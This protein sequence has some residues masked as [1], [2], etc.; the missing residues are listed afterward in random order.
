MTSGAATLLGL[1]VG[2]APLNPAAYGLAA[3]IASAT[4]L[5]NDAANSVALLAENDVTVRFAPSEYPD[6]DI[7]KSFVV[8]CVFPFNPGP[9]TY[10][11]RI[12]NRYDLIPA[13]VVDYK[14][15]DPTTIKLEI[16]AQYLT[17]TIGAADLRSHELRI[18]FYA[19]R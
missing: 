1:I 4:L 10:A 2:A 9:F 18:E 13:D 19:D 17:N 3:P 7:T 15:Y 14:Y 8:T 11:V 12:D 16:N 5:V 6:L